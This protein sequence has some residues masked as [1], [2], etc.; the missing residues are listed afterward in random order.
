MATMTKPTKEKNTPKMYTDLAIS[1]LK[2]DPKRPDERREL[3]DA[4]AAGL[5]VCIQPSGTKSFAMRIRSDNEVGC[6]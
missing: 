1:K 2:P 4:G 3:P 6:G 5:Y